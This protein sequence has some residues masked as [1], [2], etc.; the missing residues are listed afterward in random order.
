MLMAAA[1]RLSAPAIQSHPAYMFGPSVPCLETS[2]PKGRCRAGKAPLR[3]VTR[4]AGK[5]FRPCRMALPSFVLG[6]L[7]SA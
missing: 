5:G 4:H 2:P 6:V 3:P 1:S 7:S